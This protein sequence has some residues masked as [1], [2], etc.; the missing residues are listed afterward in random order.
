[1]TTNDLRQIPI[2]GWLVTTPGDGGSAV[3]DAVHIAVALADVE[4]EDGG[5]FG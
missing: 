5:A 1:M 2:D 4:F 3:H